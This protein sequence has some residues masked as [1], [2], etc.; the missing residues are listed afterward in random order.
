MAAQAQFGSKFIGEEEA[1]ALRKK[2]THIPRI[3]WED[4]KEGADLKSLS[5]ERRLRVCQ[6]LWTIRGMAL[7]EFPHLMV[8]EVRDVLL[9]DYG[10]THA[11]AGDV[12][13]FLA[14]ALKRGE[15]RFG[16]GATVEKDGDM[17]QALDILA[18]PMVTDELFA[19]FC[20]AMRTDAMEASGILPKGTL[21]RRKQQVYA[22]NTRAATATEMRT[23]K[24]EGPA[25]PLGRAA[26]AKMAAVWERAAKEAGAT[27][28]QLEAMGKKTKEA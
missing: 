17:A 18:D 7:T 23:G 4:K 13:I 5:S 12:D 1:E 8:D 15:T 22:E 27:E 2:G 25:G 11:F 6:R 20:S 9:H 16:D 3:V 21:N 10:K 26:R 24:A 19:T 28:E 14:N